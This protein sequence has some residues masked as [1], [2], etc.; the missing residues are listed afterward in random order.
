MQKVLPIVSWLIALLLAVAVGLNWFLLPDS[1]AAEFGITL[2]GIKAYSQVR[3]DIGGVF[4]GASGVLAFGLVKREPKFLFATA[5]II[6][7]AA[8]G[9]LLSLMM[10]GVHQDSYGPMVVELIM[11]TVIVLTARSFA[12]NANS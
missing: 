6:F 9:R 5:A 4:I 8:M 7:C 10:D 11:T 12:D 2:D 3:A 1:A